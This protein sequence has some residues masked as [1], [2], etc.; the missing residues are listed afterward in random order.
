MPTLPIAAP[1]NLGRRATA[2]DFGTGVGLSSL[3][4]ASDAASRSTEILFNAEMQAKV[5]SA[6]A[7]GASQLADFRRELQDDPDYNSHQEKFDKR[8]KEIQN[9]T[10]EGL[11]S[12]RFKGEFDTSFGALTERARS[13][14]LDG[15]RAKQLDFIN[16]GSIKAWDVF[17]ELA[18]QEEDPDARDALLFNANLVKDRALKTGAWT[19]LTVA[20]MELSQAR[21]LRDAENI[22]GSQEITDELMKEFPNDHSARLK[23][24]QV[25]NS[26]PMEDTVDSRLKSR[27]AQ[28]VAEKRDRAAAVQAQSDETFQEG[29][30]LLA[31]GK[32]GGDWIEKNSRAIGA[33]RRLQLRKLLQDGPKK[34]DPK[35]VKRLNDQSINDPDGFLKDPLDAAKLGNTRNTFLA[36]Q[37]QIAKDGFLDSQT[38]SLGRRVVTRAETLGLTDDQATEFDRRVNEEIQEQR[39]ASRPGTAGF[40]CRWHVPRG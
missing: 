15:V 26:G 12:N 18:A 31:E 1:T 7:D 14:V 9:Q 30:D 16:G 35:E 22:R 5:S 23:A 4:A 32:L 3:G 2:E 13:G 19:H 29:L 38:I 27:H 34:A 8:V 40:D 17:T 28:E 20:R 37:R 10:R 11:F 39:Q 25:R 6:L 33:T 24:N 36:L 21:T